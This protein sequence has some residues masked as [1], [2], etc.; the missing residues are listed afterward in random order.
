MEL[1]SDIL[2]TNK[3]TNADS[4]VNNVLE[5]LR[6]MCAMLVA[7][8]IEKNFSDVNSQ[9]NK[10]IENTTNFFKNNSEYKNIFKAKKIETI[11][12]NLEKYENKYINPEIEKRLNKFWINKANYDGNFLIHCEYGYNSSNVLS[13]WI[14]TDN[15]LKDYKSNNAIKEQL[16]NMFEELNKLG[17]Q[18]IGFKIVENYIKFI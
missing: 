2:F 16:S 4:F 1:N 8:N 11:A 14:S 17:H 9:I 18:V 6:P 15:V 12:R 10:I 3:V 5:K 7:K 13:E